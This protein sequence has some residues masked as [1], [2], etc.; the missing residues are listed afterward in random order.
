MSRIAIASPLHKHTNR[1]LNLT[2]FSF[3]ENMSFFRKLSTKFSQLFCLLFQ[4]KLHLCLL[5]QKILRKS[6][7]M[8]SQCCASIFQIATS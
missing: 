4:H 3:V 7:L 1:R 6:K 8:I 5:S 2:L